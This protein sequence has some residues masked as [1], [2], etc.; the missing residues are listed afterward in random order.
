M[1]G[2][3]YHIFY[4]LLQCAKNG[5]LLNSDKFQFCQDVVHYGGLLI[6]LSESMIQAILN[7]PVPGT[8]TDARLWFGLI[9]EVAWAYSL[10]SVM[11][12]FLDLVK[13]D[14]KFA[15][16]QSLEDAFKDSKR[17]MIDLVQKSVATFDKDQVT[18]LVLDWSKEGM[19]FLKHYQCTVENLRLAPDICRQQILCRCWA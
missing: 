16:N 14:S 13:E 1:E 4:F 5:I 2:A 9:N 8:I 12:P 6:T 3:F 19:G 17:V 15:W 18:C 7:F 10:V 11:K